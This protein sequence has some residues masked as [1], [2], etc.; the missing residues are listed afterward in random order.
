M[1]YFSEVAG[2]KIVDRHGKLV[3]RVYDI[4]V[5]ISRKL[6]TS[7]TLV[8]VKIRRGKRHFFYIPWEN[9]LH[10]KEKD[11]VVLR[12]P[13]S[14]LR[15]GGDEGGDLQLGKNLLDR[16]IVD[17]HGRKVVRVNDL[18]LAE[19]DSTLVL[20][21][22]DIGALGILRRLGLARPL[23]RLSR[24]IG[25]GLK[26]RTI[27]WN[28]VAPIEIQP[29]GLKLRI[30]RTQLRTLH[31]SDLADILEQ[32]D[33]EV[34]VKA[35]EL[36]D[37]MTAVE[38]ISEVSLEQQVDIMSELGEVRASG[39]LE[40][41]PPDEATDILGVLPRDKAE[42]LLNIMGVREAT[43]IRELLGY[44]EHTAGGKMTPKFIAVPSAYSV[45]ECI[46]YLREKAP[47]AETIY[48]IYVLD[49]EN[50]LKGVLSLRDLLMAEPSTPVEQVMNFDV[51][52]VNVADDQELVADLMNKYNF[53]ALPVVDDNNVLKGIITVDDM[54]DVLREESREDISRISGLADQEMSISGSVRARLPI[55]S[56]ILL[57]G[58]MVSLALGF[59]RDELLYT[60]PL[61][62]FL[63]IFFRANQDIG[64]LS[65]TIMLDAFGGKELKLMDYFLLTLKELRMVGLLGLALALGS[66]P[67]AIWWQGSF[68]FALAVSLSLLLTLP[69]SAALSSMTLLG[70]QSV[71][72][73]R[74]AYFQA[75][76]VGAYLN[77]VSLLVYIGFICLFT[78]R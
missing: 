33:P 41:M 74:G 67:V 39:I 36:L 66:I 55:V 25:W 19:F 45:Q 63:P 8:A 27:A 16:Q 29:E 50:R 28:Y 75:N 3:G 72:P 65:Q 56:M 52:A 6:P 17:L 31:P 20:T 49:D 47:S 60:L 78:G 32:L 7:S 71:R 23:E 62:Y 59:F 21:G 38:S 77:V 61:I 68:S 34:R 5:D 15:E 76:T 73:E 54:I 46:N 24:L 18:C 48:Y 26:E 43:V 44:E 14:E 12:V 35:I 37:T 64:I 69:I 9:I 40:K 42:R 51:I 2:R 22:V 4:G 70:F 57:G 53:L 11:R 13:L 10:L 1:L 30:A 58:I